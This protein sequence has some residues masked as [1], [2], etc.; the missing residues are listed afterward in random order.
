MST[1]V[2]RNASGAQSKPTTRER[3]E[4]PAR[5]KWRLADIFEDWDQWKSAAERLERQIAE[6][7]GLK[8]TLSQGPE[9]LK[10]ALALDS[11]LGQLSYRVWYYPAL[12]YDEDQR[13]NELNAR[14]QQVQIL[15]AKA[16]QASAWFNP[17]LL[18]VGLDTIH[19]W[20]EK[21]AALSAYRF[22]IDDL[23]RQ[24]EH[25]LDDAGERLL[26]LAARFKSTPSD[27]YSALSTADMRHPQL[28][29]S[30]GQTLTISSGQ[31]RAIL[32]TNRNQSDRRAAFLAHYG[33]YT[34]NINTYAAMYGA[35]CQRD[36]FAAQARNYNST[37]ESALHGNNI[38][39]S[40]VE[41]LIRATRAGVEPLRRYHRLRRRALGLSEY[42]LYDGSVSLV[43]RDNKY[44]YDAALPAI[45]E[46]V[47]VLGS[48]YQARMQKAVDGG[49]IDVYENEGK[50]SGAYSAG[51]YGVH[52]YMLLNYN[53]TLDDVFTLAHELG[54]TLHT[55]L[56]HEHQPFQ[57]ADYTIF[58]AEVASTLNEALLLEQMLQRSQDAEERVLLLQHAI[59]SI[60]GT[61]YTQ[62]LFAT[63]ELE[64]HRLVEQGKPVTADSLSELYIGLLREYYGDAVDLDEPY[65]MTWAR[66]P[67]FFGS[68]YYVYQY[69][70]CFAS[71]AV[72]LRE[73]NGARSAT[74]VERYLG[75]L[76]GGSSDYPMALLQRAGVDLSQSETVEAVATQLDQLVS[77]LDTELASLSQ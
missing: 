9:L 53:D 63:W 41:T 48:D 51:V 74:A 64:A 73:I 31:Y 45:V 72:I 70:T 29:L 76:R 55:M 42:H 2:Q 37:L 23:Y 66:I 54:H 26:S 39:T 7:A 6:F 44:Y 16:S 22:V 58:V 21:D 27:T 17:E 14:R 75:L 20:M 8:G 19:D 28:T 3:G 11:E 49:W 24:Q 30:D 46:S 25:V 40:V 56:S 60:V 65:A 69:A 50:R 68:P 71:S 52:P 13:D 34:N 67:H 57:Y 12:S 1:P 10:Q 32:A 4:I 61:Y 5:Y 62:V 35:V 18:S 36:W 15:F 43:D 33:C 77:R 47:A 59:D 38:P